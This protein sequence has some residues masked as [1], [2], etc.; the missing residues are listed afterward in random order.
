M[1]ADAARHSPDNRGGSEV[2]T[3]L[4]VL[5][6]LA[7]L[8]A[9][10]PLSA[11]HSFAAEFDLSQRVSVKGKAVKLDWM[12]PHA[13]LII[14]VTLP[15]GRTEQWT[16]ETP[17]PNTL[18]RAGWRQTTIKGGEEVIVN[19]F[20]AKDGANLMWALRVDFAD[21]RKSMMTFTQAAWTSAVSVGTRLAHGAGRGRPQAAFIV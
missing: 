17:P 6:G 21:G 19:G 9:A 4:A 5:A 1:T 8:T 18:Y 12:N 16:A 14:E 15:D 2:K 7:L 20:L 11:H 13:H 10:L 3:R